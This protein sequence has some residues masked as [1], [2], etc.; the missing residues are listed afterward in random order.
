MN[1]IGV[2]EL[3]VGANQ[4]LTPADLIELPDFS[5]GEALVRPSLRQ[6]EGPEATIRMEPRVM[7]VLA[8]LHLS[9][10]AVVSRDALIRACWGG[11]FVSDDSLN[12]A[13]RQARKALKQAGVETVAIETVPRAGYRLTGGAEEGTADATGAPPVG[14]TRRFRRWAISAAVLSVVAALG[15]S[16][17]WLRGGDSAARRSL[18]VLP[19]QAAADDQPAQQLRE[20]FSSDLSRI[21]LGQDASLNFVDPATSHTARADADFVLSGDSRSSG[22][23]LNAVVRL[24]DN[25]SSIILWSKGFS[26]PADDIQVLRQQ[27]AA[28]VSRVLSCALGAQSRRPADLD[29]ATLRLFLTA[30]ETWSI[31]GSSRESLARVIARR[32]DFAQARGMY[33]LATWLTSKYGNGSA[34]ETKAQ[35]LREVATEARKTL[36]QD[37]HIGLAYVALSMAVYRPE[38]LSGPGSA[39]KWV[40]LIA[41][42]QRGNT[43]DPASF[44][45][46]TALGGMLYRVGLTGVAMRHLERAAALAP[47]SPTAVSNVARAYAFHGR[48]AQGLQE[49]EQ[50]GRYWPN[51]LWWRVEQAE[52]ARR[53]GEPASAR[54]MLDAPWLNLTATQK[55]RW[56]M[57]LT[58]RENPSPANVAAATEAIR[59]AAAA[60]PSVDAQIDLIADLVQLGRIDDAFALAMR[61]PPVSNDYGVAWFDDFMAPFRAD[62][63]FLDFARRQGIYE[64][65]VR[66]NRWPD[67]CSTEKLRY[68]C[69]PTHP[70]PAK[71]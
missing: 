62:P 58:A 54:A 3:D 67:F 42:L 2:K 32:P 47:F 34:S 10:G 27:I 16:A 9:G 59:A 46:H 57:V 69:Q 71:A 8:F 12:H 35:L 21:A 30:C 65:W 37:P 60:H 31:D 45:L 50:A 22:G 1:I 38:T 51:D 28:Q 19:L 66:S 48:P 7:Q 6:I 70:G 64:V 56:R 63:R 5:C 39:D 29:I 43:A 25:H 26:G 15:A 40:K 13:I 55:R 18:V 41:M 11:A 17:L 4:L 53:V 49:L 61:L 23:S 20:S 52:I 36:R 44:E 33:A 24:L 14:K 68:K